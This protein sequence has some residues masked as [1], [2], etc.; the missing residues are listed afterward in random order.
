MKTTG[1]S[2]EKRFLVSVA[3]N[4]LA[5]QQEIDDLILQLAL[6]K[7][8]AKDKFEELKKD[9]KASMASLKLQ[10]ISFTGS[11]VNKKTQ[12]AIE[13]LENVLEKPEA[14]GLIEFEA[15][16]T[17]LLALVETIQNEVEE[18]LS[19]KQLSHEFIN[20]FE[21][22]KLKLEILNL[23]F[24]LKRFEVK[25]SVQDFFK[26]SAKALHRIVDSAEDSI[27]EG[28]DVW[29]KA[30]KTIHDTYKSLKKALH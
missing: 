2:P 18:W 13:Q 4:L 22:F 17:K 25:D 16:R 9:F 20:E 10:V 7:A 14:N 28:E 8:E 21:K 26:D 15:Q 19:N 29:I 30:K 5:A 1:P 6:G 3:E 27:A 23:K 11:G 12:D 24:A